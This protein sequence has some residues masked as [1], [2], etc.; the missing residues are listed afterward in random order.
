MIMG[1]ISVHRARLKVVRKDNF[2]FEGGGGGGGL[3]FP[4]QFFF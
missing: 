3:I 4:R 2:E 1:N